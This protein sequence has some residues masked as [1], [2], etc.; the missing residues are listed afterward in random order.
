[1]SSGKPIKS[2]AKDK[3]DKCKDCSKA[4]HD[5]DKA[6]QCEVCEGWF[7]CDCQEI[8]DATY[9]VL[10]HDSSVHWFCLY[11]RKGVKL[12][13]QGLSKVEARQ[14][15]MEEVLAKIGVRQGNF[16]DEMCTIST[17]YDK[18][19]DDITKLKANAEKIRDTATKSGTRQDKLEEDLK[20]MKVQLTSVDSEITNFKGEIKEVK[21]LATST[22]VKL[23]TAVE[24]KLVESLDQHL[25]SRVDNKVKDM[26]ETLDIE[27]RKINLIF[28]GIKESGQQAI[29][30]NEKHPDEIMIEEVLKYGLKLNAGRQI[31]EVSRIGKPVEGKIRPVKVKVKSMDSKIEILKRAKDLKNSKFSRV[32]IANDLTRKQQQFDKD[33][34]DRVKK[35]REEGIASA[36]I[37][38]GKIVKNEEDGQVVILYQPPVQV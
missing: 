15:K 32:F 6:V 31:D 19:S 18:L 4:V 25:V 8:S 22:D 20:K 27:R 38:S 12:L 34:R 3:V 33:L 5:E 24:A 13:L 37:K 23:E 26:Q 16:E 10:T 35:Y 21:T 1:M 7:H 29:S 9:E 14:D 17:N 36:R 28:H 30:E 2:V 11:C